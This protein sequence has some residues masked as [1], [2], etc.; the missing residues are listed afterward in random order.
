MIPFIASPCPISLRFDCVTVGITNHKGFR[1]PKL[2]SLIRN[3]SGRNKINLGFVCLASC[4]L[5]V[6]CQ[7]QG[8]SMDNVV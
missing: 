3:H 4:R 8:L 6:M 5:C 2:P 1:E 7:Q